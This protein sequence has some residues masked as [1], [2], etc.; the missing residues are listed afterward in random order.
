M[1]RRNKLSDFININ[2]NGKI[3]MKLEQDDD[4]V[5]VALCSVADDVAFDL[6]KQVCVCGF[7]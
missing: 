1:V 2:R 7:L 3:A 6:P 4:I 5:S